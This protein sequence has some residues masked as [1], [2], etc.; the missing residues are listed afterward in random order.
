VGEFVGGGAHHRDDGILE[1]IGRRA[2]CVDG[3]HHAGRLGGDRRREQDLLAREVA[4]ERGPGDPGR[5]GDVIEGGL[6]DAVPGE[7]RERGVEETLL[8]AR[9]GGDR[10]H[11]VRQ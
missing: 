1:V 2:G 11:R 6:G 10:D 5:P 3:R 7:A 8:G 9:G 4:V